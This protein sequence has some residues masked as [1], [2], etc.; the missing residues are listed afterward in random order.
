ARA[1]C[2]QVASR[3]REKEP[4]VYK[5]S[6]LA[7]SWISELIGDLPQAA[8]VLERLGRD[9][10]YDTDADR[11]VSLANIYQRIDTAESVAAA[12]NICN[13][14]TR[15]FEYA[16][17]LGRLAH[18]HRRLGHDDEALT[19]ERQHLEQYR[20]RM[21]RPTAAQ[22]VEVAAHRYLPVALLRSVS[23]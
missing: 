18:L 3:Y 1:V 9:R 4:E 17:I 16:P 10:G 23:F 7:E 6:V 5:L 12:V 15:N 22:V 11:L 13:F 21:H 14:L 19:Y 2:R 8:E 20:H